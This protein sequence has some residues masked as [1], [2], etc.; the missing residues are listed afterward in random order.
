MTVIAHVFKDAALQQ[1]FDDASDTIGGSAVNG[2]SYDGVFYVGS[3]DDQ[4]TIQA[5]S[6]PGVDPLQVSINDQNVGSGIE[7]SHVKLATS[8][9]GLSGATGGAALSL[10]TSI[11]GGVANA[12]PVWYRWTNSTGAG[13]DT[14]IQF[15]ITARVEV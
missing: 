5:E 4:V 6:D 1:A 9:A 12:V 10:G 14:D 3:T 2:A 15:V 8:Q 11:P 13:S 7:A